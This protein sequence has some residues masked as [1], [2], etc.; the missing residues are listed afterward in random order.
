MIKPEHRWAVEER[1]N[2]ER[3]AR[4]QHERDSAK[5]EKEIGEL[6]SKICSLDAIKDAMEVSWDDIC[7]D[8]GCHPLDIGHGK[9]KHL[10]FRANHWADQIAKRLF[11]RALKLVPASTLS[12]ADRS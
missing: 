5:S 12:Q 3:N 8:T 7:T 6:I 4:L 9:D 11:L 2:A 10:I 1:E